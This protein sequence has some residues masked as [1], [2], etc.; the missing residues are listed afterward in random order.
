MQILT[1]I[2]MARNPRLGLLWLGATLLGIHGFMLRGM[3][4]VFYPVDLTLA[5]WTDTLM[6]FI[7]EPVGEVVSRDGIVSRADE[8]RLMFLSQAMDHTHPPLVP[9]EPFG[10][11]AIV[12][13]NLEV[14][15]H[16]RCDTRH[17]LSYAGWSWDCRDGP[18]SRLPPQVLITAPVD[19]IPQRKDECQDVEVDY[20]H[21]D[22]ENDSSERVTR[23]I[24]MW[25]RGED[26][27][28]LAEREIWEHEWID[29]LYDSDGESPSPE[30]D[31]RSTSIRRGASMGTV[32]AWTLRTVTYRRNGFY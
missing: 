21:M 9:F 4:A 6:S 22:R 5:G 18:L 28:P 12:D 20:S 2:L 23:S 8:C 26:G 27:F 29:N 17:R 31:G 7:Q 24:F 25:L 15:A 14:Q 1:G 10:A 16:T 32:G 19:R 13:C 3:R 11:T 30:G